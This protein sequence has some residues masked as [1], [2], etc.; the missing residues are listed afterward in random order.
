ML[1]LLVRLGDA[2]LLEEF[3]TRIVQKEFDS[4]ENRVLVAATRVLGATKTVTVFAPL[5]TERM[6]LWPRACIK[7]L[8]A[9]AS[10]HGSASAQAWPKTL[11]EISEAVITSLGNLGEKS[12]VPAWMA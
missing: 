9:L 5:M 12:A 1:K 6:L 11:R 8:K 4:R 10:A 2:A 3:I 7:L